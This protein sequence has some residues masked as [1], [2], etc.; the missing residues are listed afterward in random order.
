MALVEESIDD[1]TATLTLN[2]PEKRN[3][4]NADLVAALTDAINRVS[5]RSGV[6]V[7]VLTGVGKSFCAGADLKQLEE[8]REQS[9]EEN[10]RDSRRLADLFLAIGRSEKPSIAR[11]NGDALGGGAGLVVS[12]DWAFM[13]DEGDIGFPE[14]RL[15]FVPAIVL[16]FLVRQVGEATARD[17]ALRG[18]RLT[19]AQAR[20]AGLI[21]AAVSTDE[22]DRA[23]QSLADEIVHAT[24]RSAVAGTRR[25]LH[26]IP[27]MSFEEAIDLV[28]TTNAFARTTQDFQTGISAFLAGES[29]SWAPRDIE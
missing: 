26:R 7:L 8:M 17:L 10:L 18:R 9:A 24:S 13:V 4:L 12:C 25:L 23:V 22:L 28:V 2:R 11:V 16:P 6:C 19:A 15:G 5:S 29:P 21:H 27:Q 14:V 3:A 20:A 1:G